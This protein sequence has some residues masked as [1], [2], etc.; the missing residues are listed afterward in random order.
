LR[1]LKI[2]SPGNQKGRCREAK[3][4]DP[5][6]ASIYNKFI[7][8]KVSRLFVITKIRNEIFYIQTYFNYGWSAV[9]QNEEL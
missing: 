5:E 1:F 6:G 3:L 8:T 9:G 7:D 4:P 2:E